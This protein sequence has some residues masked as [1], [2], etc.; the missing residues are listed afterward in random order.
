MSGRDS[1]ADCGAV[2]ERRLIEASAK[3]QRRLPLEAAQ[4]CSA[5]LGDLAALL[6]GVIDLGKVLDLARAF[7]AVRWDPMVD[8]A[9]SGPESLIGPARRSV[10][11]VA[12]G[13]PA[14]APCTG[15]AD[16]F[17]D[18]YCA[19]SAGG[20]F[21][22]CDGGCPGTPLAVGIRPPLQAAVADR[23]TARLWAAALVFP[24]DRD[25]DGVLPPFSIR[26]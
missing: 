4:G 5:G 6:A 10:V 12:F 24:I 15:Q 11:G 21:R 8:H 2:V 16:P 17:R 9:L 3:G 14:L 19:A 25:I 18:R 22:W 20:R 26:P 7:M 1:L 23:R 13:L